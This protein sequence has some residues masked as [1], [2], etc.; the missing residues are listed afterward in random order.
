[1]SQI[2]VKI[3]HPTF[4]RK[5]TYP[6]AEAGKDIK[7]ASYFAVT[8]M[9]QVIVVGY[10]GREIRIEPDQDYGFPFING[11]TGVAP[12]GSNV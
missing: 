9:C 12:G 10:A 4:G 1:M 11:N 3:M 8:Y 6:L 7:A 2:T 5:M